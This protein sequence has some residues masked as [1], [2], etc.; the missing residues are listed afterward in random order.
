M[1][2]VPVCFYVKNDILVR[3]WRPPDVSAD[4]EWTV[5]QQIVVHRAYRPEILS[6]AQETTISGHLSVNKTYH[7]LLARILI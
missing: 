3:K 2:Q 7:K 1:S 4:D 5:N 6:L